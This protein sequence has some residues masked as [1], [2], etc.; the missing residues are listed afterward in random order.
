MTD[1]SCSIW[2]KMYFSQCSLRRCIIT[3]W[4]WIMWTCI[5]VYLL[6]YVWKLHDNKCWK[7]TLYYL[8]MVFSLK[9]Y[10][11]RNRIVLLYGH[12]I[13][14]VQFGN[15]PTYLLTIGYMAHTTVSST[16]FY[17]YHSHRSIISLHSSLQ[18]TVT[19]LPLCLHR[20]LLFSL[21]LFFLA[22]TV[23]LF[24]LLSFL[25]LCFWAPAIISSYVVICSKLYHINLWYKWYD[26]QGKQQHYSQKW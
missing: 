21:L 18:D 17:P 26:T 19:F 10:A 11:Y 24:P 5:C 2:S 20:W 1:N 3:M 8:A 22:K 15:K 6:V 16:H 4:K 7:F 23:T 25:L 9:L 12:V 13:Y 14:F